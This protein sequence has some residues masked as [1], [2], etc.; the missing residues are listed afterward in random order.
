MLIGWNALGGLYL[1]VQSGAL[2]LGMVIFTNLVSIVVILSELSSLHHLTGTP[3]VLYLQL[4]A[5]TLIALWELL[6][7]SFAKH[8]AHHHYLHRSSYHAQH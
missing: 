4:T 2:V 7:S 5:T 8:Y 1:Q 3:F 6:T